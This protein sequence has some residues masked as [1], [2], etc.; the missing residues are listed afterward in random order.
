MQV[1]VGWD[2]A[3]RTVLRYDFD[4]HWTLDDLEIALEAGFTLM[5]TVRHTV[6]VIANM[7]R[8]AGVPDGLLLDIKRILAV[9]PANQGVTVVVGGSPYMHAHLRMIRRIHKRFAPRL[10]QAASLPDAR[11]M[12]VDSTVEMRLQLL[13]AG[14]FR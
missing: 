2:N 14:S 8:S 7:K 1:R 10:L 13:Y 6:D 9:M 11:R 4:G 3:E 5:G 12:L